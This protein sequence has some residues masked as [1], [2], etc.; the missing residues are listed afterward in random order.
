M[1]ID[2]EFIYNEPFPQADLDVIGDQRP[3]KAKNPSFRQSNAPGETHNVSDYLHAEKVGEGFF[4]ILR[5][6]SA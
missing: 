5:Q 3:E 6:F 2:G 4:D 1:R